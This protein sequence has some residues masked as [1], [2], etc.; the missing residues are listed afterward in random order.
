M[1]MVAGPCLSLPS[2]TSAAT[3]LAATWG[4]STLLGLSVCLLKWG[5][6]EQGQSQAQDRTQV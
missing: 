4:V 6:W 2:G 1:R 3:Y 5:F